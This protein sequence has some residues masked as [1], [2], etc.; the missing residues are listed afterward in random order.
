MRESLDE[1]GIGRVTGGGG[2]LKTSPC[3]VR[4]RAVVKAHKR[5]RARQ[6][7]QVTLGHGVTYAFLSPDALF[8]ES[9]RSCGYPKTLSC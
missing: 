5:P 3:A 4:E 8:S 2:G 7:D 9:A 1:E 6:Q